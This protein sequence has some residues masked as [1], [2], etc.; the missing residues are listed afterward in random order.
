MAPCAP[1]E[2]PA[3]RAAPAVR[4]ASNRPR[5][6]TPADRRVRFLMDLPFRR[7]RALASARAPCFADP[8]WPLSVH[9]TP[10]HRGGGFDVYGRGARVSV[11]T[12]ISAVARLP[13]APIACTTSACIGLAETPRRAVKRP[14]CEA[15]AAPI[16]PER[17]RTAKNSLTR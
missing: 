1:T 12:E 16:A 8:R 11:G 17:V 10:G 2:R 4:T 14:A 7:F 13:R 15:R 3:A 6:R 9:Q 5:A